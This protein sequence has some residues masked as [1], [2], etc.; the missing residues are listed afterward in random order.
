MKELQRGRKRRWA[1]ELHVSQVVSL[2][3]S[4]NCRPPPLESHAG[5]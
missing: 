4:A 5:R 1:E 3:P 2:E